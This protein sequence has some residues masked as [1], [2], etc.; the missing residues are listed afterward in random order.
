[1]QA[2]AALK[3]RPQAAT[4]SASK[5]PAS[6]SVAL[7][8]AATAPQPAPTA[9]SMSA[10]LHQAE[11]GLVRLAGSVLELLRMVALVSD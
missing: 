1:M 11:A 8:P 9:A 10:A 6:T 3:L 4:G 2:P 5:A 7:A